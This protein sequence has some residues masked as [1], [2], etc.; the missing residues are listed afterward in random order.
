VGPFANGGRGREQQ[1]NA[2]PHPVFAGLTPAQV[3]V[4]GG[5][6]ET[7]LATSLLENLAR[8]LEDRP[9]ESE[10]HALL[11]TVLLLH[12]WQNQAQPDG[13]TVFETTVAERNE[14]LAR[15]ARALGLGTDV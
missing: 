4:G 3:L 10:G 12:G 5:P 7:R 9:F 15:R 6:R 2:T 11:Q 14:L 1:W 13:Q 8:F